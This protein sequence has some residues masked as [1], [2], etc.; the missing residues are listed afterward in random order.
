[1]NR[2]IL[3]TLLG[4]ECAKNT[5]WEP[6]W[7]PHAP[8]PMQHEEGMAMLPAMQTAKRYKREGD[9]GSLREAPSET[10]PKKRCLGCSG[11]AFHICWGRR[12][13]DRL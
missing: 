9:E 10:L 12:A 8:A 3:P 1:M 7:L 2:R 6:Q 11:P 5:Q 4:E 13:A